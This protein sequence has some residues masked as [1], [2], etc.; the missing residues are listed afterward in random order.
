M[1]TT[2][3]ATVKH[4]CGHHKIYD[5]PATPVLLRAG[6]LSRLAERDCLSC[7]RTESAQRHEGEMDSSSSLGQVAVETARSER[8]AWG[9]QE[10]MP[11]LEGTEWAIAAGSRVRDTLISEAQNW[12]SDRERTEE[13][14][15]ERL[16][17][18]AR[19][20]PD[21][22]WWI[23][24][25]DCAPWELEEMLTRVDEMP[26]VNGDVRGATDE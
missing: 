13:E 14:F 3:T 23:R 10:E 25:C 6:V 1:S 21:A 7:R 15:T 9:R 8:E 18:P 5:I 4:I 12:C 24:N 16:V 17:V 22:S 26:V 19:Q 20:H 11:H 2:T